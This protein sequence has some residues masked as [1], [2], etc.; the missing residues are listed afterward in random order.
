MNL[1]QLE[2][3]VAIA[4]EHQITAAARRLHISQPPLSYELSQLERELGV[5]LVTREAR[6]V[7][8]TDAGRVLYQRARSILSLTSAAAAEVANVGRGL[9]GTLSIGMTSSSGAMSPGEAMLGLAEGQPDVAYEVHEGNTYEVLEMLE[10]GVVE[11][12]FVRTPFPTTGLEC[13]YCASE[14]L[15]CVMGPGRAVGGEDACTVE[16]LAGVPLIIYRRFEA[17]IRKAFEDRSVPLRVVCLNDDARTT[18]TWA[19]TGMGVG[20]TPISATRLVATPDQVVKVLDCEELA[21]RQ[22]VVWRKGRALSPLAER[23]VARLEE[24]Y[25]ESLAPEA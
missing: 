20:I 25:G 22:A 15:V 18:I 11:L 8:L 12:G 10:Q 1:K 7:T 2:Y 21:T 6:G 4:E 3:F 23:L 19:R 17:L 9:A 24:A 5:L 13:H 14:P 16:D